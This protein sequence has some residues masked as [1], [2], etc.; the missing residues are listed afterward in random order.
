MSEI[1]I[2]KYKPKTLNDYIGDQYLT[3]LHYLDE[4]FKEKKGKGFL[5]YG[6]PGVGKSALI[7][8]IGN[9][10]NADMYII[11]ASDERNSL[12]F[13]AINAP[14]LIGKK[15]IIILEEV[16]GINVLTFKTLAKIIELSKNPIILICNDINKIDNIV[17][18]K[19]FVKEIVVNRFDLKLLANRIIKEEKLNITNDQLNKDLV[20]LTSYRSLLDYLQFGNTSKIGSFETSEN[21]KDAIQFISDNSS[22]PNLISLADIYMKRYRQG[23]KNG[24]TIAK[25]ILNS[26]NKTSSDYPRTYRLIHEVRHPKKSTGSLKIIGFK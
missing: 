13:G 21:L 9:Y 3:I 6:K 19:C 10:Y 16:D 7:S 11:N 8:V 15:R 18:S 2:D 14:S 17:K 24:E 20:N 1:W 26:I 4:F 22:S 23:Y 12:N 25:Y 5:I